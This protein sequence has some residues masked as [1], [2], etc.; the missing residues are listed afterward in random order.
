MWMKKKWIFSGGVG[1]GIGVIV[2][3][4]W[5]MNARLDVEKTWESQLKET[6]FENTESE[7]K[8]VSQCWM[9]GNASKSLMKGL[10]GKD[11]LGIIWTNDWY[12]LNMEIKGLDEKRSIAAYQGKESRSTSIGEGECVFHT[13]RQPNRGISEVTI[14]YGENSTFYLEAVAGHL[15]QGCLDKLISVMETNGEA[16]CLIDF[17]S[18]ELYS[19]QDDKREYFI[20]DYYVRIEGDEEKEI[21]A[22]YA[23]DRT[24]D[25]EI[26]YSK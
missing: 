15:C 19:L 25:E 8:D 2:G 1:F 7:L 10:R 24:E 3:S 12:V 11:D 6:V 4:I 21:T 26:E 5:T 23:P 9:C 16:I 14:E 13:E 17:L 20:R 22:I 18:M